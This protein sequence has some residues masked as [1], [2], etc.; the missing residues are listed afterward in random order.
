MLY[1]EQRE[2]GKIRAAMPDVMI[3][4]S[5]YSEICSLVCELCDDTNAG[6][7]DLEMAATLSGRTAVYGLTA[8]PIC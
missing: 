8:K 3:K 2:N 6:N 7:N 5:Q 4:Y 1:W